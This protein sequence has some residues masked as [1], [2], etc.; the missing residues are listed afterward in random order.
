MSDATFQAV[1]DAIAAHVADECEGESVFV[2]D[3]HMTVAAALANDAHHTMYL[4][5]GADAPYHHKLGL[6]H[7][8]LEML[9]TPPEYEADDD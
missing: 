5:I 8:G 9:T 7:R 2:T 4:N 1:H 3:W 6:M